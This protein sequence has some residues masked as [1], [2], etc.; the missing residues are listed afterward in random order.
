M[1]RRLTTILTALAAMIL[2]TIAAATPAAAATTDPAGALAFAFTL[3]PAT[4][5]QLALTVILP[6]LVGLVTTRI[7]SSAAKAWLLAA[8]TL[9]TSIVA[10]LARALATG[11]TFDVGAAVLVAVPAFAI[12]VATHYGLWK[13]TG[14]AETLKDVGRT[15]APATVSEA[16]DYSDTV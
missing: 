11:T 13:P 8:L 1:I 4:V 2:I 10:E 7:T 14:V 3:D 5:V 16:P 12:S 15:A 9:I 6:I